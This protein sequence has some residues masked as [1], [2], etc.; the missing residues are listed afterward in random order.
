M[1]AVT[2][3]PSLDAADRS[4]FT[5]TARG[6]STATRLRANRTFTWSLIGNGG[7]TT[8]GSY[9]PP[10]GSRDRDHRGD[11][12]LDQ[13]RHRRLL[14]RTSPMGFR[15]FRV[16]DHDRADWQSTIN[17]STLAAPGLRGVTGDAVLFGASAVGA[18]DLNGASPS[19]GGVT[20]S[21]ANGATI[22]KGTGGSL[23]LNNGAAR[24]R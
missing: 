7:L 4:S 22:A 9:T 1:V 15:R 13:R 14:Y 3:S 16:V 8:G 24:P 19:L 10:Y 12:R 20:F 18:V 21:A 17:G 5:A 11:Q 2:R 23:L 6:H